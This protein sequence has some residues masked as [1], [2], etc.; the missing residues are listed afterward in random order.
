M[1][2]ELTRLV[3]LQQIGAVGMHYTVIAND[4]ECRALAARLQIPAVV[5]LTCDFDLAPPN[6]DSV[7]ATGTLRARVM[8]TCVVSLDEF[9]QEV[10][11]RFEIRFV[12]EGTISDGFDP[13]LPDE[14]P[15]GGG[16]IDVGTAA[17]EQLALALD[18]Y[19]RKQDLEDVDFELLRASP[20]DLLANLKH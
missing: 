15:Y 3:R 7:A 4:A 10:M 14:L 11:E 17:A 9:E 8:Q 12:P 16:I 20:F 18:P 6:Q 1:T 19:P 13:E 2:P 5:A